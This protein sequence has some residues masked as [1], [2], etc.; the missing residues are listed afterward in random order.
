M[1]ILWPIAVGKPADT[2]LFSSPSIWYRQ[3]QG[4]DAN[5]DGHVTK[6]EAVAAVRAKLVKGQQPAFEG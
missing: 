1:A 6:A 3:N 5:H 4:L 2:I